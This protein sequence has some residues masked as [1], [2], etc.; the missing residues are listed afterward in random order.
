MSKRTDKG[1]FKP[2]RSGNPKGRPKG[3]SNKDVKELRD[4]VKQLLDAT[5]DQVVEDMAE[6]EPKDRVNAYMKLLEFSLPK[7]KSID[8]KV[9]GDAMA[10][11]PPRIIIGD[12]PEW[13][14]DE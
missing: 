5:F 12:L 10:K 7:L 2:G 8:A 11:Q 3:K 6:L 14:Q 4:R 1:Q 9:E 13:M